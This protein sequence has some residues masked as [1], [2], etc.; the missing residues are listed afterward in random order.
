[1]TTYYFHDE[2]DP[3]QPSHWFRV[4]KQDALNGAA[5]RTVAAKFQVAYDDGYQTGVYDLKITDRETI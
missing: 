4:G 5:H 1:M 3:T 2:D